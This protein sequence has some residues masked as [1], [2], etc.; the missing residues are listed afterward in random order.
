MNQY[1]KFGTNPEWGKAPN[2]KF[3]HLQ[4]ALTWFEFKIFI[5]RMGIDDRYRQT[6]YIIRT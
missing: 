6:S 3:M 2:V 5:W 1:Y 4:S